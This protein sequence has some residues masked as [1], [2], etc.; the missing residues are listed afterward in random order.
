MRFCTHF[1]RYSCSQMLL[2]S[3][4]KLPP[5]FKAELGS[6]TGTPHGQPEWDVSWRLGRLSCLSSTPLSVS[7][8][9]SPKKYDSHSLKRAPLQGTVCPPHPFSSCQPRVNPRWFVNSHRC[10]L[11]KTSDVPGNVLVQLVLNTVPWGRCYYHSHF[12]HQETKAQ[13]HEVAWPRSHSGPNAG[14]RVQISACLAPKT[15]PLHTFTAG[16]QK[17]S[18]TLNGLLHEC[19]F[20]FLSS[21]GPLWPNTSPKVLP[22]AAHWKCGS[23]NQSWCQTTVQTKEV[24][25]SGR[26]PRQQWL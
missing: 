6:E 8:G 19:Y 25:I 12:T 13:N 18:R 5:P 26:G 23:I 7:W 24:S 17:S 2:D 14:V 21:L 10:H 11:P 16:Q 22:Q 15:Y 3:L 9:S 1:G 20:P 4:P